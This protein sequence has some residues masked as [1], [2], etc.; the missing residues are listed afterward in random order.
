MIRHQQTLRFAL[1]FVR[2]PRNLESFS[3][4]CVRRVI[5]K[6]RACNMPCVWLAL[7]WV[8]GLHGQMFCQVAVPLLGY[9]LQGFVVCF[10]SEFLL[11]LQFKD[12]V[13][14]TMSFSRIKAKRNKQKS[15]TICQRKLHY[16]SWN[17]SQ[18]SQNLTKWREVLDLGYVSGCVGK[19][20]ILWA[21]HQTSSSLNDTLTWYMMQQRQ[22]WNRDFNSTLELSW[23][24]RTL[25][26]CLNWNPKST[27]DGL[28]R[29]K[30]GGLY[31]QIQ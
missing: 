16:T 23:G 7:K 22:P 13:H 15:W 17:I 3:G 2:R 12:R 4:L 21:A 9:L 1:I 10:K 25:T 6:Q 31:N 27:E 30:Q 11:K 8:P 14:W 24:V 19:P 28:A 20:W 18:D 29:K 26:T 5:L